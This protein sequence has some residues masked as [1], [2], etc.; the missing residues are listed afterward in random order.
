M[1]GP[2]RYAARQL[3]PG[4]NFPYWYSRRDFTT[5]G[6]QDIKVGFCKEDTGHDTAEEATACFRR[7]LAHQASGFLS[8]LTPS[9]LCRRSPL[10]FILWLLAVLM[11]RRW[12]SRHHWTRVGYIIAGLKVVHVC[13]RHSQLEELCKLV[14][15]PA[16]LMEGR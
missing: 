4:A 15:D 1:K 13:T 11:P 7:F 12:A 10:D 16:E 2:R 6:H 5:N 14:G 3:I 9:A 8:E